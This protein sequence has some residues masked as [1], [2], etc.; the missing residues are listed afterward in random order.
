MATLFED[1]VRLIESQD[2]KS[3]AWKRL[4]HN[5]G[6]PG[7]ILGALIDVFS[8]GT[9]RSFQDL[10]NA[11][12]TAQESGYLSNASLYGF[13]A[14][15]TQIGS[16]TFSLNARSPVMPYGPGTTVAPVQLGTPPQLRSDGRKGQFRVDTI[17]DL[18]GPES[19]PTTPSV[20]PV[21]DLPPMPPGRR[22]GGLS[23]T[24]TGSTGMWESRSPLAVAV[25][26]RPGER[27]SRA[28][29]HQDFTRGGLLPDE[30]G[31]DAWSNEILTPE[32]SNVYS[33]AY[34]E[35]R[36]VLYVTYRAPLEA[37]SERDWTNQC[38][39]K[40]YKL[41]VRPFVRGPMYAYGGRSR[42]VPKWMYEEL[43]STSSKG[44]WVWDR[45]RVCGSFYEHQFPVNLVSP[46]MEGVINVPRKATQRG[47]RVRAV[48]TVGK[49]RR[50]YMTSNLP[51][52]LFNG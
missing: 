27:R 37:V 48:P 25:V 42:P 36:G 7:I 19:P 40:N 49:G 34:D 28:A 14:P 5:H 18:V 50:S 13:R 46:S 51:E 43:K 30:E 16:P 15:K 33:F 44:S 38:T 32:S 24:P 20:S 9:P 10:R 41:Q 6:G 8:A 4:A 22:P 12:S 21:A 47:F 23:T 3:P 2:R 26:S 1:A 39:G 29:E 11:I 17:P 52:N 35:A 31:Q 45:L